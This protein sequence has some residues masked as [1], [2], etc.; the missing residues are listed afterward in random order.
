[1]SRLGRILAVTAGLSAAGIV[2]GALCAA[3][4]L[5]MVLVVQDGLRSF[6]DPELD[7]IFGVVAAAGAAVGAVAAPALAW[8]LL[9]RV[10]LGRAVV[11]TALGTVA[12]AGLGTWTLPLHHFLVPVPSVLVGALLGFVASGVAL[13]LRAVR[14][15]RLP[16][17]A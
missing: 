6:F 17:P 15:P 12:G 14:S 10:P 9:R 3:A 4:T 7:G 13:R 8:G 2:V 5:A 11:W 16:P 1:M